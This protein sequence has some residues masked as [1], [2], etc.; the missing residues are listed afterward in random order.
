MYT[1]E[2]ESAIVKRDSDGVQIEPTSDINSQ[3]YQ[4]YLTWLNAG[5][6][7]TEVH[8][9][10]IEHEN[11]ISPEDFMD[12][13]TQLELIN[14]MTRADGGDVGC[15]LLLLQ[16]Q[17]ST[18]VVLDSNTTKNGILYLQSIGVLTAERAQQILE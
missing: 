14:I 8:I 18:R 5:N 6:F 10:I 4:D 1:L 15:K 12:R 11:V 2:V 9:D 7:P 17:I 3:D 13:F 16:T